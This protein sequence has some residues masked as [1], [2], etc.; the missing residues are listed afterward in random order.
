MEKR[1]K[2]NTLDEKSLK[3][4]KAYNVGITHVGVIVMFDLQS[5][6]F[7]ET[8][9]KALIE[10]GRDNNLKLSSIDIGEPDEVYQAS[11][12]YPSEDF[13]EEDDEVGQIER[14]KRKEKQE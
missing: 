8:E 9:A 10:F 6:S 13:A 5:S 2:G 11:A 7:S 12:F 14:M 4:L 3:I 1:K